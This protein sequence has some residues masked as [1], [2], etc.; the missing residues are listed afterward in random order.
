MKEK[1]I[2]SVLLALVMVFSL[3]ST[4]FAATGKT[5]TF[6]GGY[7]YQTEKGKPGTI[8][9]KLSNIINTKKSVK[10]DI[11]DYIDDASVADT[12]FGYTEEDD[13]ITLKD[14]VSEGITVYYAD[15]APV[16]ATS[17][18]VLSCF[19]VSYTGNVEKATYTPKYFSFDDYLNNP[20]NAKVLTK[21]PE[22]SYFLAPG[23]KMKLTKSGKYLFIVKDDGAIDGSPIS[24]FCV[25]V[26]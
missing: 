20:D 9:I 25:I 21:K 3:T 17:K 19:W 10:I 12:I 24:A 18:S 2:L 13:A 26:K 23:T 15:K 16:T 14:I 8:Q 11:M 4:V 5:V 6:N 22:G 1:S 7:I